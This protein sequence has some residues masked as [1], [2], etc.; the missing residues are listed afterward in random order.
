M[1]LLTRR[2]SSAA[3]AVLGLAVLGLVLTD[4]A[5]GPAV[6]QA[7][8]PPPPPVASPV[9]PA[10]APAVPAPPAT[11]LQLFADVEEAWAASDA[12][13]L[14]A[15]VDT[16]SVRISVKPDAPPTAAMN[17]VAATFLFQDPMRLVRTTS[18]RVLHVSVSDRGTA[19]ATARWI[20]DWGGQRGV[21]RVRVELEAAAVRAGVWL[22][23]EVRSSD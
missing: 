10:P 19:R 13:R 21:R 15:L 8:P 5:R 22:L 2:A 12:E 7:D 18:F 16:T 17:R 6:A 14:G 9:Q 20:G 1:I 4:L 23:T 3:L 11:A